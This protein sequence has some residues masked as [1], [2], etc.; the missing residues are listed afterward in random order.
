MFVYFFTPAQFDVNPRLPL[1]ISLQGEM[2]TSA[3]EKIE[4]AL[5]SFLN[6]KT[7]PFIFYYQSIKA[8]SNAKA[9]PLKRAYFSCFIC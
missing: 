4:M 9:K 1:C 7:G 2:A 6:G 3:G 8:L 5:L